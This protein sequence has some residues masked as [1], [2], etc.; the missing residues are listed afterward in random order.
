MIVKLIMRVIKDVC[1]HDYSDKGGDDGNA[2]ET[3][4]KMYMFSLYCLAKHAF[5]L[6]GMK[7][8]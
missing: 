1:G 3:M 8:N 5:L 6:G 4:R 2:N 7:W